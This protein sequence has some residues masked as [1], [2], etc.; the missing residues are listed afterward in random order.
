MESEQS[1][2]YR[3]L[4]NLL[5]AIEESVGGGLLTGGELFFFTDNT[6]AESGFHRGTTT[7]RSLFQ[8][9]LR[10]QMLQMHHD[11][12]IHVLHVAGKRMQ[13]QGTDG[14]SWGCLDGGVLA[15]SSM[16]SFVPLHLS[17]FACDPNLQDWVASWMCNDPV[18]WL[19]PFDWYTLG[20][21]ALSCILF[22]KK[23]D[24]VVTIPLG[25]SPW[26]HHH[27]EP[28]LLGIYFPLTRHRP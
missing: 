21:T 20:H 4:N 3:E 13:A 11:L 15:G 2:N 24:F 5:L 26:P 28:L 22:E 19:T 18:T 6:T 14:L 9:I 23:C 7:S 10:M 8:L 1:S 17:A 27:F 25:S 12:S 16:L